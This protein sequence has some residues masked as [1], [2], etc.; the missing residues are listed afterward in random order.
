M[1]KHHHQKVLF[2]LR[3][4]DKMK[5]L[6]GSS[7]LLRTIYGLRAI[8]KSSSR[9]FQKRLLL[10]FSIS[11]ILLTC[12]PPATVK[13]EVFDDPA[14]E[15]LGKEYG[16]IHDLNETYYWLVYE[17]LF[18]STYEESEEEKQ[19]CSY[20]QVPW[21]MYPHLRWTG[22]WNGISIGSYKFSSFGCGVCCLSNLYQTITGEKASPYRMYDWCQ[23]YSSYSPTS[24]VGAISWSQMKAVCDHLGL[25]T[26]LMQK[27][28]DYAQFQEQ[29]KNNRAML[30]LVCKDNDNKLWWYTNGHYVTIWEYQEETD[31][32]FVADP[33]GLYNRERVPLSYI[34]QALKTQS[35]AQFM[36][37]SGNSA[38]ASG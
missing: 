17:H 29:M 16:E 3:I 21:C 9:S 6:N 13:A 12:M 33:S 2:D 8:G 22:P 25:D 1:G 27:P 26:Q 5:F 24:S 32:V 7:C 30:V 15:E 11:C 18:H 35:D 23:A 20:V 36:L 14:M 31:S 38:E 10:L 34:Y 19:I 4:K 28:A 37:F